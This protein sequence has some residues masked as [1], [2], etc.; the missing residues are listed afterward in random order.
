MP[1]PGMRKRF[2][3]FDPFKDAY[4]IKAMKEQDPDLFEVSH[5]LKILLGSRKASGL[6]Y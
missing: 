3:K 2:E 6:V 1:I 4:F 5:Q